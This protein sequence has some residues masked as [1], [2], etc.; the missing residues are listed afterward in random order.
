MRLESIRLHWVQIPFHEPFRISS[1][2][3]AVKHAILVE[4]VVQGGMSGWGEAS[5]MA[6]S[7]YSP[8][9]PESTW[10]FL[11]ERLIPYF[12]GRPEFDPQ[13]L[14]GPLAG[15]PGE[16]FAKAGLEGAVWELKA[17]KEAKPLWDLLGGGKPA[18]PSGGPLGLVARVPV[19]LRPVGKIFWGGHLGIQGKV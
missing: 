12:L 11:R 5:P 14:V 8:E 7:F 2:E 3:V 6:G 19:L 4:L 15:F 1:G 18:R 10:R 17:K 13:R 9:T 16:P